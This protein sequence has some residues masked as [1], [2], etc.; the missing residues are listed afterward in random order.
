MGEQGAWGPQRRPHSERKEWTA[1]VGGGELAGSPR[2]YG[3]WLQ[4]TLQPRR[5]RERRGVSWDQERAD[6][7]KGHGGSEPEPLAGSRAPRK[8]TYTWQPLGK[9][10]VDPLPR[11]TL[12]EGCTSMGDCLE[13]AAGS[14]MGPG[15][16]EG[17]GGWSQPQTPLS[18]ASE[19]RFN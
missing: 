14:E 13:E 5:W 18:T 15:Y 2:A 8:E 1:G 19:P 9:R 11:P 17:C 4:F 7:S 6:G 16:R 10:A 3:N 12:A